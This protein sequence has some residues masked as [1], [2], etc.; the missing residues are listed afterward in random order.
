MVKPFYY[1]PIP[2]E[3]PYGKGIESTSG[4]H[5]IKIVFRATTM[6]REKVARAAAKVGVT[7][8]VF[9]RRIINDLADAVLN[10]EE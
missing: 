10:E 3:I 2:T 4:P 6:E 1:L 9:M 8:A 5:G 7:S